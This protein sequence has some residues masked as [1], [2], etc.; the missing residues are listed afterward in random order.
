MLEYARHKQL[1]AFGSVLF[2]ITGTL[3][4]R[5]HFRFQRKVCNS[6]HNMTQTSMS[7]NDIAIVTVRRNYYRMFFSGITNREAVNRMRNANLHEKR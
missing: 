1:A 3:F 5:I 6:C 4:L 7:L 2:V